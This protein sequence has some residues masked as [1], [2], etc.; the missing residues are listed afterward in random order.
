MEERGDPDAGMHKNGVGGIPPRPPPFCDP[1]SLSLSSPVAF[2]T[3]RNRPE[4]FCQPSPTAFPTTPNT[5][6]WAPSPSHLSLPTCTRGMAVEFLCSLP[7][8]S[9]F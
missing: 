3:E 4:L 5:P 9:V 6:P 2:I 1:D 8:V 7:R